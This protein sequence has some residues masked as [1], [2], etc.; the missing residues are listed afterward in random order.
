MRLVKISHWLGFAYLLLFTLTPIAE[1]SDAEQPSPA[2]DCLKCHNEL[3]RKELAKRYI[4]APFLEKQCRGCHAA[5]PLANPEDPGMPVPEDEGGRW[6]EKSLIP[7]TS[8]WFSFAAANPA[9]MV[10]E[11]SYGS[12]IRLHREIPLPPLA[13]LTDLTATYGRHPPEIS[14]VKVVEVKKEVFLT[15]SIS[16]RTDRPTGAMITYGVTELRQT[17]P[18]NNRLQTE[19]LETLT[20]LEQGRTYRFKVIAEDAGGNRTESA[21][22]SFSTA[23]TFANP[24]EKTREADC[25]L[26]VPLG[27]ESNFFRQGDRYLVNITCAR[28]VKIFFNLHDNA[29]TEKETPE[30]PEPPDQTPREVRHIITTEEESVTI[31]VCKGCHRGITAHH[32]VNVFPKKGMRIPADYPTLADGRISCITCHAPHAANRNYLMNKDYRQE[33]CVGCHKSFMPTG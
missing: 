26:A 7:A 6:L 16:W 22:F 27:L 17:T 10:L 5:D 23:A 11:A 15:A 21:I 24:D 13:D 28:P 33:L 29:K 14:R 1:K 32:P 12:M 20:N 18:R 31:I 30:E 4:H 8:H 19:H 3:W 2:S 25:C 9:T